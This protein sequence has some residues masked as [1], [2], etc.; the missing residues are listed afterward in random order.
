MANKYVKNAREGAKGTDHA[1]IHKRTQIRKV[2]EDGDKIKE[3]H[4]MKPHPRPDHKHAHA[5][6]I[7]DDNEKLHKVWQVCYGK[8]NKGAFH[9]LSI[10]KTQGKEVCYR[11]RYE[12][13]KGGT[14]GDNTQ[15]QP[16]NPTKACT[17]SLSTGEKKRG[18]T[19][20]EVCVSHYAYHAF[21][22]HVYRTS[23]IAFLLLFD[24]DHADRQRE[25]TKV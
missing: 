19:N 9:A 6:S 14:Q 10:G 25:P 22:L 3:K 15:K 4:G 18:G 12:K 2:Q 20:R 11:R 23:S 17:R 5:L 21:L 16:T 1:R 13:K 7:E 8:K 24:H